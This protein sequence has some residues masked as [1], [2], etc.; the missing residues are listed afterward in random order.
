MQ[1]SGYTILFDLETLV[2]P[3]QGGIFD[4]PGF[5]TL[6]F[7]TYVMFYSIS[8]IFSGIKILV[9]LNKKSWTVG[10]KELKNYLKNALHFPVMNYCHV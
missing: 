3:R 9:C 5:F 10:I 1:D 6:N 8:N 2:L 4:G 7:N